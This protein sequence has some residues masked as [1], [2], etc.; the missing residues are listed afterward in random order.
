MRIGVVREIKDKENRVALTP[1]GAR[2][3]VE[4]GH[5]VRI[6]RDAGVGAGHDDAAYREVGA[7]IVD[8]VAAWDCDLVL[9]VKEPQESEFRYFDGQIL[10]TYLHLS[11][12]PAALTKALIKARM[13]AIAYET[14]EDRDGRFPLLMPMSAIAGNMTVAVG[15]HYLARPNGGK[16]TQ[17]GA[18]LGQR[19]GKVLVIGDGTVG[20]HATR[21]ADGMGANV[22][23]FGRSPTKYE[24]IRRHTSDAVQYI[25]STPDNIAAHLT[26]ADLVIGAVLLPGDRAPHLVSEAMIQRM[27]PGSVAIDVSVDQG[28]CFETTRA[29]THSDPVYELHGVIHYAVSNMPGAYPRT[30]TRALTHATLPY[31]QQLADRGLDALHD[32]PYFAKGVNTHA[33]LI[34]CKPVAH[35][36]RLD[37]LYQPFAHETEDAPA[38]QDSG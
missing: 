19:N 32:D 15:S 9:K 24:Q 14:V 36:H 26:D 23:L 7:G 35:A 10:F 30:A 38:E 20:E 31:V 33:G 25:E 27:Q 8:T 28:G 12:V 22:C 2:S 37:S 4:R 29:T 1:D 13:T 5:T 34:T 16:G 11:G 18:V 6:E 3:L 17:L 21:T